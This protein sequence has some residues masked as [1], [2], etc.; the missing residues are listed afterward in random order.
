MPIGQRLLLRE[1]VEPPAEEPVNEQCRDPVPDCVDMQVR[2][3]ML[4]AVPSCTVPISAQATR[5]ASSVTMLMTS[6]EPAQVPGGRDSLPR[7]GDFL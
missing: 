6:D 5:T 7:Q 1:A 4:K 3:G 2:H